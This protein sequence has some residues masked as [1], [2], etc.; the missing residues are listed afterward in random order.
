[1]FE[2][3][4]H[5]VEEVAHE[6]EEV[7]HEVEKGFVEVEHEVADDLGHLGEKIEERLG[8]HNKD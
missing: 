1:M 8:G 7:A 4:A 6:V 5:E 3:V 2:A